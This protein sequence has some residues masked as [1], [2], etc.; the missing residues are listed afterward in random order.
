MNLLNKSIL[1]ASVI[2]LL[3]TIIL[4]FTYTYDGSY[5]EDILISSILLS[6]PLYVSLL[7]LITF[8]RSN[9]RKNHTILNKLGISIFS[10]TALLHIL[11]NSFM[12]LD[13]WQKGSLGPA[14][15]YTGLIL[16]FGS[17]K[18]IF[19]G[20]IIGLSVHYIPA[21]YQKAANKSLKQDK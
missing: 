20:C 8:C 16:W 10:C 4:L 14:Q 12:L 3:S 7:L 18:A 21:L 5:F 6:I 2:S 9:F 19:W 13:V 11:W 1:I 15:G 17:L